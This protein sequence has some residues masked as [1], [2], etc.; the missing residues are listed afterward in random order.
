MLRC[1]LPLLLLLLPPL[2][3][4]QLPPPLDWSV[5]A[6]TCVPDE[7]STRLVQLDS[8][9]VTFRPL[10]VASQRPGTPL[11]LLVR[12]PI[13]LTGQWRWSHLEMTLRDPDSDAPGARIRIE[14]KRLV[15]PSGA[16]RHP[17]FAERIGLFDTRNRPSP[18]PTRL[19]TV[20]SA[21]RLGAMA[22]FSRYTY[23][24]EIA[25]SRDA[26]TTTRPRVAAVRLRWI[27]LEEEE[28]AAAP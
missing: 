19:T 9:G 10:A 7:S 6:G 12:C 26:L 13:P 2:A 5:L 27:P 24:L 17:P 25:M 20:L 8:T 22:D 28:D 11:P 14:L 15:L 16:N 4:A 1:L 18:D 3:L 23:W 21:G